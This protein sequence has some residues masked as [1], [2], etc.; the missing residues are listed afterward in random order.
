MTLEEYNEYFSGAS[1]GYAIFFAGV[2]E[3]PEHIALEDLRRNWRGFWPP[4]VFRYLTDEQVRWVYSS[5]NIPYPYM[6]LAL[7]E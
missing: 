5:A 3:L 4:Q 6:Q 7:L 2:Q 1:I